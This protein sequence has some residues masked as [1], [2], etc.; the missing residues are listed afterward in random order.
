MIWCPKIKAPPSNKSRSSDAAS[1]FRLQPHRSSSAVKNQNG[2]AFEQGTDGEDAA[3]T[4][5]CGGIAAVSPPS[6][7][8]LRWCAET[9]SKQLV[10]SRPGAALL[11]RR[12]RQNVLHHYGL[13]FSSLRLFTFPLSNFQTFNLFT[14]LVFSSLGLFGRGGDL[15]RS[16]RLSLGLLVSLSFSLLVSSSCPEE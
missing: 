10:N 9:L 12:K 8:F 15:S 5:S 13:V 7:P 1:T 4:I 3:A 6:H 11:Q 14:F 2:R 16:A